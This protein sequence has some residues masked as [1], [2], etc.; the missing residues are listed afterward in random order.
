M[1]YI[2]SGLQI[3]SLLLVLI[4]LASPIS[5]ASN[6]SR[7][8]SLIHY[9][10]EKVRIGGVAS[11]ITNTSFLNEI[12]LRDSLLLDIDKN[13]SKHSLSRVII[14]ND[15]TNVDINSLSNM[16]VDV[17]N[18]LNISNGFI[19]YG[20][21]DDSI[22]P[23]LREKGLKVIKDFMLE[24]D[25]S[26]NYDNLTNANANNNNAFAIVP[27]SSDAN[28]FDLIYGI[29]K[30]HEKGITGKGVN[31]AVID[32]GVD[33]SSKD[34]LHA[35]ALDKNGMPIMLD[36]D[37]QGIVLT[38][39]KF[40]AKIINNVIYEQELTEEEKKD[41]YTSNIYINNEGVF[42]NIKGKE[43]LKFDVYNPIY[44]Y[45][46][47]PV[48]NARVNADWKIG[49][50]NFNFIQSK[51]GVYKMGFMVQLNFQLGRAAL[52]IVPVLVIDSKE[53]NV[54]D[55]I[56]ADMSTAWA[57]F[58]VF[59]LGKK[60][61]EVTFD[62][63]FTDEKPITL[64]HHDSK[65]G[66][67]RVSIEDLMLTYDA[68][69]DGL[70][71]I[72]VGMLGAKVLDVWNV[73]SNLSNNKEANDGSNNSNA[74]ENKNYIDPNL[75]A[76]SGRLVGPMDPNGNYFTVMFD[77]LGHGTQSAGTIVSKGSVDYE[78]YKDSGKTHRIVGIAPD[79]KIIPVKALWFGDI[80]Y[81]WL[82]ASGFDL[83]EE[84]VSSSSDG[85]SGNTNSN[86]YSIDNSG[87]SDYNTSSNDDS[88][89]ETV[90]WR[91]IY[92]GEHRADIIN[93]SWGIPSVP[94]L[95][96]GPGYDVL[97]V[98]ASV[99]SI[100]G[101]LHAEYP[102]VIIVSSN[103]N[104]GHAYG[105]VTSP[106]SSPL[107]LSIGATTNNV[108]YTLQ[109]FKKQP[110]FGSAIDYYDDIADFSSKGPTPLGDVKPDLLA[111]GAYGYTPLPVNVK[112]I[113][114]TKHA[115]GV[116]GGTS[117][118]SP[119]TAGM[120]ALVIQALR[121][122]N[123]IS[124]S[125]DNIPIPLLARVIL[126]STAKD[127]KYDPFTQG[128]GRVD[129]L[130]AL[131]YI[132]G[133]EG[134]FIAYTY[135]TYKN[136]V[137]ALKG[138]LEAY[139]NMIS[140]DENKNYGYPS[141]LFADKN[142]PLSKWYAG[143][144]SKG[145][146][147]DAVFT[148]INN[149]DSRLDL[150]ITPTTLRLIGVDE[151]KGKTEPR[152]R[153][154]KFNTED[155][156]YRPKYVEV[157]I[158]DDK[159]KDADLIIAKLHYPFETFMNTSKD[160]IYADELR[161]ASLY[162]YDWVDKDGNG[163]VSYD[164]LA[165]INRAGAWGTVQNLIISEPFKKL[166]GKML[167]GIYQVPKVFSFWKGM[168][169]KDSEAFDYTLTLA[170][171]KRD[172]WD[173]LKINGADGLK[174]SIEPHGKATFRAS[175]QVRDAL[176][177][178]YQGYITIA[179][180]KHVAN[181]P[182]SFLVPLEIA[183]KDVPYV[184][185][186]EKNVSNGNSNDPLHILYTNAMLQ[187]SFDMLARYNA[188]EW[189]HY[190][191]NIKDSSVNTLSVKMTWS[192]PFSSISVFVLDPKGEIVA[193]NVPAG[194]FKEFVNWPSNDWLGR[195]LVSEG[196]GF[197][198]AHNNGSNSTVLYVPVKAPGMY[199]LMIH[200]TLFHA[201]DA[202]IEP[203]SIEVKPATILPDVKPPSVIVNIPSYLKGSMDLKIDA[204]DE[205]LEYITY[206]IDDS[207][208]LPVNGKV[209]IDTTKLQDGLH[210]L[211]IVSRDIVGHLSI[212]RYTFYVDNTPPSIDIGGVTDSALVSG[213][214]NIN[215]D[216]KDTTL[217]SFN[218]ILPDGKVLEG[219]HEVSID[220]S[221]LSD[222]IH[223]LRVNAYD[224]AGNSNEKVLILKVDNTPPKVSITT[225]TEMSTVSGML[226]VRYRIEEENLKGVMVAVD[227][228]AKLVEPTGSYVINTKNLID[229][230]HTVEVIAED[231]LGHKGNAMVK[232]NAVNYAPV[233]D[234][235]KEAIRVSAREQGFQQGTLVGIAVGI[236]VGAGV[237]IGI[238]TTKK[239]IAQVS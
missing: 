78:I 146:G 167:I 203:L 111:T 210:V 156:G 48:L 27:T 219:K 119:L 191:L 19:A 16:G 130:K 2:I 169:D 100:P 103:G 85:I 98:L 144:V 184:I 157:S 181:I 26:I 217:K 238:Y 162:A 31:I 182:V 107:A 236:A 80:A 115:W 59:E 41:P 155:Y 73:I 91:W 4:L 3:T 188:G 137:D 34:M 87:G 104:S 150:T 226:E 237:A 129:I 192:N 42:L 93:N 147:N 197:Y 179:S 82:W 67:N 151:F 35:I 124:N 11:I 44:P 174:L 159:R 89:K 63:D 187:G 161:I 21:A 5:S 223:E 142:I 101:S 202:F 221:R 96:Y 23:L 92:T 171:Y 148:I 15:D 105:T 143:A 33:F 50:D 123:S 141:L 106:A 84:K 56:I 158:N 177:G 66:N 228:N 55:T 76:L 193:S 176:E 37:G 125:N 9:D 220:T 30:V 10:D 64:H 32:T 65:D 18:Y 134:L 43:G 81:A 216:V 99:L 51:S 88:K 235:E 173:M 229:G 62:L 109:D 117:M 74:K 183:D 77:F 114:N 127:L 185:S 164:E 231:M 175:L 108:I 97:S 46:G 166:K 180:S 57:D 20:V 190:Y 225:P 232:I 154:E 206:S 178:I 68:D 196:G 60:L 83:V 52:I 72:S 8:I 24:F 222:G 230:E 145:T 49:K 224:Y 218:V 1:R 112:H 201:K 198:P 136:Y 28:R 113:L 212:N 211:T 163:K 135:D 69:K 152:V 121:D 126:T 58:A 209:S 214:L 102:G 165:M 6:A 133:S 95:G 120:L 94:L 47:P 90:R 149:S 12:R 138:T 53:P 110:R 22:L 40:K 128:S 168:S 29:D 186:N 153:D 234:A 195:T 13:L 14:V 75:G 45:L 239:R 140:S 25:S 7:P 189:K 118:A 213:S 194:V 17:F 207:L 116:F 160:V 204:K 172:R 38:T 39:T 139:S 215:I 54:Y 227:G 199:T 131:D 79:A 132:Q 170:Y 70:A 122:D 36:P 205:N 71:D 208:P 61:E 200:N 86:S 233:I